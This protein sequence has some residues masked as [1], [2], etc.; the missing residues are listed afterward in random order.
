[1][2]DLL[3]NDLKALYKECFS[4][5]DKCREYLFNTKLGIPNAY[6]EN[7]KGD[8][9]CALYLVDKQLKYLKKA[10]NTPFIVALATAK[11]YRKQ[12]HATRLVERTLNKLVKPFVMLYPDVKGFYEKMDFVYVSQD[13]VLQE[14]LI[15]EKTS[16]SKKL[17]ELYKEK[18]KGKDYYI[19]LSKKDFEEKIKTTELDGKHYYILKENLKKTGFSNGEETI[20]INERKKQNGVMARIC[21]I[22]EAFRLTDVSIPI[23]IK[24]TDKLLQKNNICFCVEKGKIIYCNDYDVTISVAELT[25]HF[26]GY[27]GKLKE[28]FESIV[29]FISERY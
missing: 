21:D 16:D 29:G 28:Y 23:K 6:Y 1:M 22:N 14:D 13:D 9:V 5:S 17:L 24:L 18:S 20:L 26:F 11:K 10:I 2:N 4:D 8:I 15:R 25:A 12:G 3:L 7:L 27:K 19:K